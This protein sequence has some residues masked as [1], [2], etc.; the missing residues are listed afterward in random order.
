MKITIITACF[1]S[2]ATIRDTFESVLRQTHADVEHIVV[3]GGSC[4]N[5]VEII[6]EYAEK[7]QGRMRWISEKDDGIYYAMNKGIAMATGEV[8]GFLNADDYYYDDHVLADIAAHFSAHPACDAIHGDLEFI[9]E[10]RKVVRRWKGRPFTPGLF[11]TGWMPAH[12]TFYCRRRCYEQY[13]SFEASIGSA[14][15]FEHTL[16][17]IEK[18]RI[19]T[20][21]IPRNFIY[22]RAGGSSNSGI[23]SVLRNTRQMKQAF[24]MHN[25]PCPWHFAVSR[26]V[27]KIISK[28]KNC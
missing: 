26:V 4:D 11:Q 9:N 25:L 27:R 16:R 24:R 22:M 1:N 28:F 17:F 12:P 14:A 18:H 5:T 8:V 13:G 21:Y 3:D 7:Y 23:G 20:T 10:Q 15:D 2:S 19:S 6:R